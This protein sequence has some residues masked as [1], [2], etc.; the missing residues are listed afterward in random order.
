VNEPEKKIMQSIIRGHLAVMIALATLATPAWAQDKDKAKQAPAEPQ[1]V[2]QKV[3]GRVVDEAGQPVAGVDLSR[4]WYT[5][6]DSKLIPYEP[7]KTA[8]DGAFSLDMTFYYGR[9]NVLATLDTERKRGG[10]ALIEPKKAGE[11]IT[12]KLGPL[13]H[14][15]GAYECKELGKPIGWTNTIVFAMPGRVNFSN[16][17]SQKAEFD[18]WLPPGNYQIQGYGS[19]DVAQH[20]REVT[21]EAGKPDVDLGAIYLAASQIAKLKGKEAPALLSTDARGVSKNVQIS[22]YKGKWVALEFWGYWCG[23][24]VGGALPRM[25]EIYDDHEDE[26]DKYVVL[27]VHAPDTKTFAELDERVKP[28][29]RDIWAGRMIPFPI[30]LDADSKIQ[31][32][33]GVSH[34]P[35]TLLFDPEGKL[36]GEVQPDFLEMKL[37]P[38][39][40]TAT[41]PRKLE[42]NTAIYFNNP[43]LKE[44]LANL[45]LQTKAEFELDSDSLKSLAL[46]ESTKVP[47]T[48]AGQVS[49]RS[50]LELLL[51]PLDLVATIGP[52][53]YMITR[54]PKSDSSVEATCSKMQQT[55][56][57][58]IERK[59][60]ES[61]YSFDF[62]K[63]PLAKVAAFFEAQSTE[64]VVLDPRGRLQGKIDPERMITGSG[65]DVAMGAALEKLVGPLGLHVVVRDEVIVLEARKD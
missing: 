46:S 62:D 3:Q 55:C 2:T 41:L 51:D 4:L 20:K 23:P 13:I 61:K 10:L 15:H 11:P 17:Q 42:R 30:L 54:K 64:N 14:F 18:Y 27:T 47:L 31:Q 43:T 12:V 40:L 35:T 5:G 58:R 29:V 48:I 7:V 36:V 59:L 65:K 44:A 49:L 21:L 6:R 26:R 9:P 45:K 60:K 52:K 19:S 22:D 39:P 32:T 34:W 53:G 25:M 38:V 24:C 33:F 50:A 1:Q 28:V 63:A 56:A 37:K 57:T 8:A 16:F